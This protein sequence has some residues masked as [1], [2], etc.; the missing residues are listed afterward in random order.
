MKI[1]SKRLMLERLE[2]EQ[3]INKISDRMLSILTE[4]DGKRVHKN[5]FEEL[6]S[7]K[8]EYFVMDNLGTKYKIDKRDIEEVNL[9]VMRKERGCR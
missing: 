6:Y 5:D 1:F 3:R 8:T 4:L 7:G 2:K 9:V